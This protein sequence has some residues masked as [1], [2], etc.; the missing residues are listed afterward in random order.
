MYGSDFKW[1][2]LRIQLGK[3]Y[4]AVEINDISIS[5]LLQPLQL[6]KIII[7]DTCQQ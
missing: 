1:E 5:E 4:T 7:S 6:L 2:N 3:L